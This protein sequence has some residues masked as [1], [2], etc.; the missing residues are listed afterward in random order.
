[1]AYY[2]VWVRFQELE[3]LYNMICNKTTFILT[4]RNGEVYYDDDI[5]ELIEYT[6]GERI[7]LYRINRRF[8]RDNKDYI[9]NK[10]LYTSLGS[11]PPSMLQE[12]CDHMEDILLRFSIY[13]QLLPL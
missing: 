13:C 7:T 9:I 10:T 12:L 2:H 5:R 8:A 1:M 4:Y 6:S 3:D 11:V